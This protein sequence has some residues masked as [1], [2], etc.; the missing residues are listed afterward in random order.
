MK[1]LVFLLG[2][3]IATIS[4]S[5][6]G[7]YIDKIKLKVKNDAMGVEMNYK[8]ISFQWIDTLTVKKQ[9]AEG[10]A[11]YEEEVK[12]LLDYSLF[13]EEVLTKEKLVELRNWE[14]KQRGTPFK[15][16]DGTKYKNYEEFAFANRDLSSFISDLCNQIEK[17]DKILTEWDNLGKG[18]LELIRNA[19][20]YYERQDGYYNTSPKTIWKSAI[21]LIDEL[22]KLQVE[23][24]RLSEMDA[25]EV[26]EYKALNNYTINN[27]LLNGAEVDVK[28]YFIFDKELNIIRTE[29]VE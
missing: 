6:N 1:K 19:I 20:W 28:R 8:S 18:N 29:E 17:T 25:N 9:L 21:T 27:P 3:A 4:C 22:E 16:F 10:I 7:E 23:N 12:P 14:N 13:S 24:D 26:M 5:S 15:S 11:Q 2:L